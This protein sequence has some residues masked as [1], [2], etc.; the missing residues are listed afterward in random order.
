MSL[1]K[2]V[3][4]AELTAHYLNNVVKCNNAES[5]YQSYK[6]RMNK[7]VL[8]EI[9][10]KRVKDLKKL[11]IQNLIFG[12]NNKEQ[13]ISA[14]TIRL[15]KSILNNVLDFAVDM[16]LVEKNPAYR[17]T[18]PKQAKYQ[19]RIYSKSE[20]QA[21]LD[22]AEGSLLYIP[23]LLAVKTGLRRSEILALQWSDISFKN[24]TITITKTTSGHALSHPKT[25]NSI[26]CFKPPVSLML[27]LEKYMYQEKAF[28]L[29]HEGIVNGQAFL[30][31]KPDG[32][33]YNP[34]YIS[35]QFNEL[36]KANNLPLI[37]FHDLR[38]T[39][40]THAHNNGMPVKHLSMSLGH[41]SAVTTIDNYVHIKDE[42]SVL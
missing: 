16:E 15:I 40:A 12:L 29:K 9:G 2:N 25:K 8:S 14:N 17:V 36:L 37:R 18:L 1:H 23:I 31:S 13:P 35:R 28:N 4:L 19:P 42:Y 5:T 26:R 34:S 10:T 24:E 39:Y 32:S 21:L 6:V 11:D 27:T 30:I 38:H 22:A 33:S 7:H 3:T 41:N 20:I